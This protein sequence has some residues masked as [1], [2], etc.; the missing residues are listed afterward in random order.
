VPILAM[1]DIDGR[2]ALDVCLRTLTVELTAREDG[3]LC[4]LPQLI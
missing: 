1:V 2:H 3:I 4:P